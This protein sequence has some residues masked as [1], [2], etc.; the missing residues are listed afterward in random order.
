M[1]YML[2]YSNRESLLCPERLSDQ[3]DIVTCGGRRRRPELWNFMGAA[4]VPSFSQCPCLMAVDT[5]CNCVVS[6]Q[7][8]IH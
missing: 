1:V 5:Y 6:G 3:G 8:S 4:I 2:M 7:T